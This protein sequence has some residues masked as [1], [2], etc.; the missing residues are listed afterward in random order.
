[1]TSP[2]K[3]ET[4]EEYAARQA[5]IHAEVRR[6]NI[7]LLH[8]IFQALLA[9]GLLELRPWK[10]RTVGTLGIIASLMN[11]YMLFPAVPTPWFSG[12]FSSRVR[13]PQPQVP[14]PPPVH[15]K[16]T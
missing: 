15:A 3:G 8:A 11:C 5:S 7:V 9:M 12:I 1:M 13:V 10:P 4:A 16:A 14:A 6:H 2:R